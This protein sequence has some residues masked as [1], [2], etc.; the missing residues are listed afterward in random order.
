MAKSR[1][2]ARRNLR[3]ERRERGVTEAQNV[4]FGDRPISIDGI[5]AYLGISVDTVRRLVANKTITP[6]R[7]G[8]QL[9]FV[10][11]E[12]MAE[13]KAKGSKPRRGSAEEKVA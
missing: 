3:A 11:H 9:R 5:A 8:S 7:V 2:V 1:K 4:V 13:L 6:V 12:V 10:P